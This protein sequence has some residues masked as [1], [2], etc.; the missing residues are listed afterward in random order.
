MKLPKNFGGKGFQGA[1]RDAQSAMAR[2]QN[3]ENELAAER[4]EIDK[5]PVKALFTGTGEMLA[6]KI[7]PD[8]IDPDDIET[9][10]DLVVSAVRDGFS[11]A[12]EI[13]EARVKEIMPSIPGMDG[14]LGG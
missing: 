13:R 1:L 5:G 4:I 14:L 3:L 11:K 9:L 8:V 7:S 12:T 2:A 10:E 6:I